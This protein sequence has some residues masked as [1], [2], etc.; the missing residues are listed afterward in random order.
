MIDISACIE[1]LEALLTKTIDLTGRIVFHTEIPQ[2]SYLMS[3]HCTI[4]ELSS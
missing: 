4:I 2:H 3:M 1:K